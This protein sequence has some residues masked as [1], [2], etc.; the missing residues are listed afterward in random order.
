MTV[1]F[2]FFLTEYTSQ[3]LPNSSFDAFPIFSSQ[4]FVA[5]D[6]TLGAIDN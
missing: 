1:T 5:F 4:L 6:K 3:G 2:W